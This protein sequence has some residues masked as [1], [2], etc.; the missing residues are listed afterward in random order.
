MSRDPR[1]NMWDQD[2]SIYQEKP[3]HTLSQADQDS[4]IMRHLASKQACESYLQR[5]HVYEKENV[6]GAIRRMLV[7]CDLDNDEVRTFI[8]N[9]YHQNR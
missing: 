1:L 2:T 6:V 7:L 3:L 4:V 9:A 5:L 8:L